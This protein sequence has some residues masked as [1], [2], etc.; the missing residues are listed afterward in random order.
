M[1]PEEFAEVS[2][3]IKRCLCDKRDEAVLEEDL[4]ANKSSQDFQGTQKYS[5]ALNEILEV[6]PIFKKSM[7]IHQAKEQILVL[8]CKLYDKKATTMQATID[9]LFKKK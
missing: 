4:P 3:L 8:F 5:M 9:K 7:I 6:Y 2:G 1:K